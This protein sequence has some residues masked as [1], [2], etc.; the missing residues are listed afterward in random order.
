[1]DIY[2]KA[3]VNVFTMLYG[4][5]ENLNEETENLVELETELAKIM[6]K[7]IS[8]VFLKKKHKWLY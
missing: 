1:M 7:Y 4:K 6:R 5:I 2:K 8:L 3:I